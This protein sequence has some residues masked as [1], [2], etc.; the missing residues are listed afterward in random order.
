MDKEG[1]EVKPVSV[2]RQLH[3]EG[4][5]KPRVRT[6]LTHQGNYA[7]IGG[8]SEL[9]RFESLFAIDTN[10]RTI[11]GSNVFAAHFFRI[12]LVQEGNN[13]RIVAPDQDSWTFEFH[14]VPST[15]NPEMLAI[16]KLANDI[17]E[18]EGLPHNFGIGFFNDSDM[19]SHAAIS[20]RERPIYRGHF[21]PPGFSLIYARDSGQELGNRLIKACH[22]K[23]RSHLQQLQKSDLSKLKLRVLDEDPMVRFR[24]FRVPGFEILHPIIHGVSITKETK[25][26]VDIEY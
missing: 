4:E 25:I 6:S 22:N 2:Q 13:F 8:L 3:Y 24:C 12:K 14:N 18:N 9:T 21:L 26:R 23:A 10:G 5:T 11:G 15:E 16:L 1:R 7:S 20:A 19:D 17:Q